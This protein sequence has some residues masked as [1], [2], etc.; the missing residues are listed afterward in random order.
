LQAKNTLAVKPHHRQASY[1]FG[2]GTQNPLAASPDIATQILQNQQN[3][4]RNGLLLPISNPST[5]NHQTHQNTQINLNSGAPTH[6]QS[7]AQSEKLNKEVRVANFAQNEYEQSEKKYSMFQNDKL[8][9]SLLRVA[10]EHY[11]S[12]KNGELLEAKV[13]ELRGE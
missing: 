13:S 10:R 6:L 4:Q 7:L 5:I 11:K 9:E 3:P 8:R 12:Q 2:D 1:D